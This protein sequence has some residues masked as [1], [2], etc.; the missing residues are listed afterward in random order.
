MGNRG[1]TTIF[2]GEKSAQTERYRAR[3]DEVVSG[4]AL[5]P[6]DATTSSHY[7]R[8]R[9]GLERQGTPIGVNDLR[10]AAQAPALCAVLVTDNGREFGRAPGLVV[11]NWLSL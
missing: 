9:A 11:E 3:L 4:L 8:I 6:L 7:A 5:L 10:I 2:I 1:Q